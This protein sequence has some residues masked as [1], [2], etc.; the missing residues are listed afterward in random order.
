MHAASFLSQ[1]LQMAVHNVVTSGLEEGTDS[2]ILHKVILLNCVFLFGTV[3]IVPLG[4]AAWLGGVMVISILDFSIV[5]LMVANFFYL[6]A[7]RNHVP[8]S[9]F[10]ILLLGCLIFYNLV[11]GGVNNA[12]HYWA[13]TF[14]L[15]ACFLLG[16]VTGVVIATLFIAVGVGYMIG[17][18]YPNSPFAY[19][20]KVDLLRFVLS[21]FIVFG[22]SYVFEKV[23]RGTHQ[24]LHDRNQELQSTNEKLERITVH[25]HEMAMNADR[26]NKAKSQFLA[27]MSHEIRTPMNGVIGAVDLLLRTQ[28]TDQQRD[29]VE[30]AMRCNEALLRIVDDVLDVSRIEAGKLVLKDV[31]FN[32]RGTVEE[33]VTLFAETAREKGVAL[34]SQVKDG[35]PEA[36]QGDPVRL[37]QVLS[38]LIGNA[39][40][41]TQQGEVAVRVGCVE[42]ARE[43]VRVRFEVADTG[44]GIAPADQEHVFDAFSQVDATTTRE[45]GGSGLGLAIAKKLTEM[46][47]GEIGVDSHPGEGTTFWFTVRLSKGDSSQLDDGCETPMTETRKALEGGFTERGGVV[48]D[49]HLLLAE[50]NPVNQEVARNMLENI[51]C[52]VE[53]VDN[54]REAV[55]AASR[56]R[57]DIILMDCQMPRMDGYEATAR[58]REREQAAGTEKEP[59]T[60]IALTA[61][62][63]EGDRERCLA[64]GMDDY[65]AKPFTQEQLT[66]VLERWLK[67][68]RSFDTQVAA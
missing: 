49:A 11:S 19:T 68:P 59:A 38:N 36:V 5:L 3:I 10:T 30:T 24:E 61:H 4:F 63:M 26:A 35:I 14:P 56:T 33:T 2:E 23:R 31:V 55:E 21:F 12:G 52:R 66:Q 34:V 25:A 7:T 46:M 47:G 16:H 22:F 29:Y 6:R 48:F 20:G 51:G 9:W 41:F 50:D 18:S 64:A 37:G 62:A 54:G 67:R 45:F 8:A 43:Q 17:G 1:K 39:V 65:L 15:F 57:F 32:L 40:K 53:V 58:I 42:E 13:F 27:N 60:I 28:L 44:I